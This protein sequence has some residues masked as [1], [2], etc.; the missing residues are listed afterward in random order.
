SKDRIVAFAGHTK[1]HGLSGG[2]IFHRIGK[3][4]E[5]DVTEQGFVATRG[6]GKVFLLDFDSA[7]AVGGGKDFV[8]EAQAESRQGNREGATLHSAGFDA[9]EHEDIFHEAGHVASGLLDIGNLFGGFFRA[10]SVAIIGEQIGGGKNDSQGRPELVR[11]HRDKT[12][13]EL[14]EFLFGLQRASQIG[15]SAFPFFHFGL[16]QR[17]RARQLGR[18]NGHAA[19]QK[20]NPGQGHDSEG[21][22]DSEDSSNSPGFPRRRLAE[23]ANIAGAAQEQA[24]SADG[25]PFANF[26][27]ADTGYLEKG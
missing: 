2:R 27:G 10:E 5:N 4:I 20:E 9:T 3:Q 22:G 7:G 6:A 1:F 25:F 21:G 17:V 18:A 19:A 14:V 15:L 24:Q 26:A 11:N 16:E 13:F 12:A 23:D 8:H